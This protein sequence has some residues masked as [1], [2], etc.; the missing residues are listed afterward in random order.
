MNNRK[1]KIML[2]SKSTNDCWTADFR[3]SDCSPH[4]LNVS[5]CNNMLIVTQVRNQIWQL[6]VDIRFMPQC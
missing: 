1:V 6:I 2:V 5:L 4:Y 3:K